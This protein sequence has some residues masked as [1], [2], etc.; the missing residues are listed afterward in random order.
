M[1]GE[2]PSTPSNEVF[3]F[4]DDRR[5]FD[6]L[7]KQN[8][9]RYWSASEL[10][11]LLGYATWDSF[12]A[13]I[14]R[15]L[16]ACMSINAAV[17]EN[18]QQVVDGGR[19][20]D[21]KLSKFA[22]F[23]VAMNGDPKKTEVARAQAYFATIA[24]AIQKWI[25]CA[26][27]VERVEIRS[28][29]SDHERSLHGI[30]DKHGVENYPFFQ[31]AGYR[32]LYNKNIS[33]VRALKGIDPKRSP[34]DFMGKRELAANLFRI[35]ETEARITLT[36][37]HGQSAL[38]RIAERVGKEVRQTMTKDGGTPPEQLPASTDIR[39][40][41]SDLKRLDKGLKKPDA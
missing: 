41:H 23:L 12:R 27:D 38:E 25:S 15:A 6:D 31:N 4:D 24:E 19:I 37:A 21:Y 1:T 7:S 33:E 40:I 32:G 8:G 26:E 39:L 36:D 29:V 16:T 14:N 30:A 28:H 35:T 10:M 18:F 20:V 5:S 3:H 2:P 34:L 13:V 17:D 11:T 22:C 9:F